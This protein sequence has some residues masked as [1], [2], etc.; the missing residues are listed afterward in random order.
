M[1]RGWQL[2]LVGTVIVGAASF[3]PP[4]FAQRPT[5]LGS[6]IGRVMVSK[7]DFTPLPVL[8]KLELRGA[9]VETAYSD[10]Q[11]RFGFGNLIAN[12]YTVSVGDESYKPESQNV[13]VNPDVSPV[14]FVQFYLTPKETK[15]KE[16]P[17][18]SRVPGSNPYLVDPAEYYR[19]FPKKTLKE[20]EKG[21]DADHHG[22]TDEAMEHYQ[23]TISYSPDFYPAHNNLGSDYLSQQN[24]EQAREHFE[25]ALRS[26]QNDAEAYF[27]LGNVLLLTQHYEQAERR[28]ADGLQR[29]PDSAFGHFLQG[30]LY[31]RTG[32]QE[33]AEKSLL[34]ALKLDPTM[35]QAHL[36]LV[37]LYM[38]Q[39]RDADA[40]KELEAYL[41]AFPDTPFSPKARELLRRLQAVTQAN[42]Q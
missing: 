20:F 41:K 38:Q 19:K 12:Q 31:S 28:I 15:K 27:N 2:R 4:L 26:N 22:R 25:A 39:K 7:G 3:S 5:Q 29:R 23:K 1:V 10:G 16:E 32:R 8:V 37:N 30:S 36:Q 35:S 21:V 33:Q 9:P 18:P 40:I 17:A 24:F 42:R 13:D 6:I 34:D 14:N 11:G